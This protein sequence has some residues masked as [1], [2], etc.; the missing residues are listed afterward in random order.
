MGYRRF[1]DR[2]GHSWEIR[3]RSLREWDFHPL[4]ENPGTVCSVPA[5]TYER[6]PYEL[7]QE[8]LQHLLDAKEPSGS[9]RPKSPFKD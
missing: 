8:E 7:S 2:E 9:R 4:G 5:P 1:T 6:D 3:T